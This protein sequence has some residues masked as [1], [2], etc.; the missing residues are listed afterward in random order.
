M[1]TIHFFKAYGSGQRS[2]KDKQTVMQ[3]K[4]DKDALDPGQ[5]H[6][7]FTAR[8]STGEDITFRDFDF[9]K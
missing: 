1:Q 3:G 5:Y 6:C 9:T 8:L 7:T 4:I 2:A